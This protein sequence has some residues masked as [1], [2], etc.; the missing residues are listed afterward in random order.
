MAFM[1]CGARSLELALTASEMQSPNALL[2][3][4]LLVLIVMLGVLVWLIK[5][6][7]NRFLQQAREIIA[8]NVVTY[9]D[10]HDISE[11]W[12]IERERLLH[13]LRTLL[14][15]SLEGKSEKLKLKS[16]V[17]RK[18][19]EEHRARTPFSELPENISLQLTALSTTHPTANTQVSQLAGSLG[20]LYSKHQREIKKQK[21]IAVLSLVIGF[22]SLIVAVLLPMLPNSH[23]TGKE[24]P[25]ASGSASP[26]P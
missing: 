19:V 23:A 6:N 3:Y 9:D 20:E 2:G 7:E 15:E 25:K 13:L 8:N 21:T 18:L 24:P 1:A 14:G 10:V 12:H 16:A 22:I 4:L 11:T 26:T 17:I 5:R